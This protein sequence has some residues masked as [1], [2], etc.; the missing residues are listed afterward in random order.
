MRLDRTWLKSSVVS[1]ICIK[2]KSWEIITLEVFLVLFKN[3]KL[4]FCVPLSYEMSEVLHLI[5]IKT[6]DFKQKLNVTVLTFHTP[7]KH[8]KSTINSYDYNFFH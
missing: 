7:E 3:W 1:C 2:L 8:G 6:E 5:C 4:I